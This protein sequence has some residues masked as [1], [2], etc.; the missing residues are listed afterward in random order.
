[1]IHKL[2]LGLGGLFAN[3]AAIGIVWWRHTDASHVEA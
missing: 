2:D 1:M 3:Y